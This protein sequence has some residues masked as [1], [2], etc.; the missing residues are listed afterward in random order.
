VTDSMESN[1]WV[2]Q[3]PS[4]ISREGNNGILKLEAENF[5]RSDDQR[6]VMILPHFL[7]LMSASISV[8]GCLA[9]VAD[10]RLSLEA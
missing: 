8:L 3:M 10:C 6:V 7:I 9:S 5:E 4:N 2:G 1:D